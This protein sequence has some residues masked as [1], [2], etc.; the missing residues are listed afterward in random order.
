MLPLCLRTAFSSSSLVS[1]FLAMQVGCL[2]RTRHRFRPSEWGY[3][4]GRWALGFAELRLHE[5]AEDCEFQAVV[6]KFHDVLEPV[7]GDPADTDRAAPPR[8]VSRQA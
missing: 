3:V 4:T 5:G 6:V 7:N 1:S 2:G 8:I